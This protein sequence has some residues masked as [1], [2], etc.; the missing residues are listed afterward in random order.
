MSCLKYI[1]G[2]KFGTI[3]IFFL[4]K[5]T[6]MLTMAAFIWWKTQLKQKY[7]LCPPTILLTEQ[8]ET[9]V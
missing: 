7:K 4:L 5:K 2:Q 9:T 8:I 6:L 3:K 1:T